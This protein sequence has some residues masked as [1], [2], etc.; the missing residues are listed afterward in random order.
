MLLPPLLHPS[1]GTNR[2]YVSGHR[3]RNGNHTGFAV[4]VQPS[5]TAHVRYR[6]RMLPESSEPIGWTIFSNHGHVLI[7][8]AGHPDARIRDVATAVGITERR[9]QGI[10]RELAD[11]GF[12]IVSKVGRRNAYRLNPEQRL[13]HPVESQHTIGELISMFTEIDLPG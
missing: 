8:I 12:L 9:A 13:R 3:G 10:V 7:Y 2:S 4:L 1:A 6:L 11:G 5:P